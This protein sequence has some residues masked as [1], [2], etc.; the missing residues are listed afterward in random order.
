VEAANKLCKAQLEIATTPAEEI[1]ALESR[2]KRMGEI[3]KKLEVL[4]RIGARGGEEKE[5]TTAKRE[6]ESAQIA[7]LRARLK[8][9]K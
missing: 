2:F 8:Q 3:E 9:M 5:Y 7:L 6:R 1:D 4:Y